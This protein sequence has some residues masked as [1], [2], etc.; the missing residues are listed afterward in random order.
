MPEE[1]QWDEVFSKTDNKLMGM[2]GVCL[3]D[4]VNDS[5]AI[6]LEN[7]GRAV[8]GRMEAGFPAADDPDLHRFLS[9][10]QRI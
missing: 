2:Y 3:D 10:V 6:G 8:L 4:I 5:G 1:R 7:L 9:F